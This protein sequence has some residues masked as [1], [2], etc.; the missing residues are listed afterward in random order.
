MMHGLNEGHITPYTGI[1]FHSFPGGQAPWQVA[2]GC[3]HSAI[4]S[5]I[6]YIAP[7]WKWNHLEQPGV[8]E[9]FM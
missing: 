9:T 2:A 3:I 5:P 6:L 1:K 4:L 8:Q 7:P